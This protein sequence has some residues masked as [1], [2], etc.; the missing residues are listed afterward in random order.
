M[1]EIKNDI[2]N[3]KKKMQT[4]ASSS[5]HVAIAKVIFLQRVFRFVRPSMYHVADAKGLRRF[6]ALASVHSAWRETLHEYS[7]LESLSLDHIMKIDS[8][9]CIC[10]NFSSSLRRFEVKFCPKQND[11]CVRLIAT[12]MTNLG[13]LC[14]QQFAS[15]TDAGVEQLVVLSALTRLDL[16]HC[17]VITD[18]ALRAVAQISSLRHLSFMGCN[19][20]SGAGLLHLK[21]LPALEALD[22]S[23]CERV[24]DDALASVAQIPTLQKLNLS[25]CRITDA[26]LAESVANMCALRELCLQSC[27]KISNKGLAP[28]ANLKLLEKL[29]VTWCGTITVT[30]TNPL[31]KAIP[32]LEIQEDAG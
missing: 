18:S 23:W 8:L 3:K 32:N 9:K 22:L 6:F 15:L 20:I 31:K 10:D 29:D 11:E 2:L 24:L 17:N 27:F 7:G 26:G 30:G 28:L 25:G 5:N 12:H 4:P 13:E 19:K 1:K 16:Q 21:R 14:L